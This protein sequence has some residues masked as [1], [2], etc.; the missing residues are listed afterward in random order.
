MR[1]WDRLQRSAKSGDVELM[2]ISGSLRATNIAECAVQPS[3]IQVIWPSD[4]QVIWPRYTEA[5]TKL[6]MV[7]GAMGQA[8]RE[9]A[10]QDRCA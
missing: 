7:E 1:R 6:L 5:E 2:Q 10:R 8:R 3:D 9:I 4:I